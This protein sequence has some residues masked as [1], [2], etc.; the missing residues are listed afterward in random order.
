MPN[1]FN[2]HGDRYYRLADDGSGVDRVIVVPRKSRWPVRV[3]ALPKTTRPTSL[4]VEVVGEL[5]F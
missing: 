2:F 1:D 5:A 4:P 3:M